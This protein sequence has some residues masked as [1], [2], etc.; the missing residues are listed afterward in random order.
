MEYRQLG[1]SGARVSVIGLGTN[2]FG[3]KVDQQGVNDIIDAALEQGINF[4]DTSDTYQKG[5]SE[6][7][8]GVALKGRWHKVVFATKVYG[9]MGEEPNDY[10]A[11]RH[12]IIN[13]VEASLRRLQTDHIDLY[14]IHRWDATTPI[15]ETL[16]ALDD[17]VSS[18]KIRYIG[19]SNYAAWQLARANL[20]AEIHGWTPFITIQNH[21]HMLERN[22][23]H[24]VLPYCSAYQVGILPFFPL[25]G[26][27]LTGKYKRG[28]PAPAGSRGENNPYVQRYMTDAN[29]D[30]IERLTAWAE[31]RSHTMGDLAHAWLLGHPEVSSVISG[32]TKV[33]QVQSNAQAAGWMLTPAELEET[34]AVLNS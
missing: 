12:H 18:G 25:A 19:A 15:E 30:K 23:E 20:L 13:G 16:R 3:G 9:K 6:E 32:A 11:S 29:Y 14:Q 31:Q 8:L 5:R 17:L 7:T 2:Q 1:K 22:L 27:F 21:Y 4:I 28:E 26:G 34:N 33:S 24:E 10:G